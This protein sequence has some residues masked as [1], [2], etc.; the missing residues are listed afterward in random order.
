MVGA[1]TGKEEGNGAGLHKASANIPRRQREVRGDIQRDGLGEEDEVSTMTIFERIKMKV[2]KLLGT[3]QDPSNDNERLLFVNDEDRIRQMKLRE[4]NIWYEGDSDELLNFYTR[5]TLYEYNYEP[6]YDRNKRNYFWGLSSVE[7]QIKRTHSG[8]ARDIVD[9]LV[10]ITPFPLIKAGKMEEETYDNVDQRLREILDEND[11]KTIYRTEQM[12]LT[13]VEGWGCY[14]LLWD[15]DISD[16]P[17]IQYYRASDV[18][19]IYRAKRIVGVIFKDF[20]NHEGRRYL[21]LETRHFD[22][23]VDQDGERK[24]CLIVSSELFV[25][26]EG[27]N[28]I[29][30]CEF[31]E[32][33]ELADTDPCLVVW[34]SNIL[35]AVPVM[36]FKNTAGYGGYGRSIFTGKLDLMD[37]LDQ[38]LSQASQGVKLSTPLEY[39]NSEYLER[40]KNG[41][42]VR[43]DYYDRKFVMYQGGLDENGAKVGQPVQVTQPRVDVELYSKDALDK[44][45]QIV[46]GV[47]SPATLGIDI[48]K[49][50]NAEAQREKEK[51]TIFTRN[52]I[53]AAEEAI[54][55]E[56]CSQALC[57]RELM[58]TGAM[59]L[60]KY[61]ISIKF[62]EFADD[63]YENKLET[64]GAALSNQNISP[65]IYMQKLYGD[66]LSLAEYNR[67]LD[68]LR[69]H[70][71]E[72]A[73]AINQGMAGINGNG[74]NLVESITAAEQKDE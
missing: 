37:D 57:M 20:Y 64:L 21:R 38:D 67:E 62:N 1:H 68:W 31:S 72:R 9:T 53:I 63:S 52:T 12:P 58:D 4:Y 70:K 3:V 19:F 24:K 50:D 56:V 18:D 60:Q 34:D 16:N 41:M 17:I 33:P 29:T 15:R 8:L 49:K 35:F 74:G 40:D 30:P 43:P 27:T 66:T 36:F 44:M 46:N 26:P 2:A 25:A 47:M 23:R 73:K 6:F 11:L 48:A 7:A 22:R 61:D 69:E 39:I 5:Q 42:P 55:R 51:V 45:L 71:E 54:L 10:A 13:L 59:T 14:K 28:E 65:E 32:V